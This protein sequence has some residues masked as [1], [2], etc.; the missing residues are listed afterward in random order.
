MICHWEGWGSPRQGFPGPPN[1]RHQTLLPVFLKNQKSCVSKV[2][3]NLQRWEELCFPCLRKGCVVGRCH[4]QVGTCFWNQWLWDVLHNETWMHFLLRDHHLF[5]QEA[6]L[7][8]PPSCIWLLESSEKLRCSRPLA[9][10]PWPWRPRCKLLKECCLR[11]WLGP[12]RAEALGTNCSAVLWSLFWIFGIQVIEVEE[13]V[14]KHPRLLA[15]GIWGSFSPEKC[16]ASP[17][18]RKKIF[19]HLLKI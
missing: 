8:F 1:I 13:G 14:K 19:N 16:G 18:V 15:S 10:F 2:Q 5:L 7:F 4:G 6:L 11:P 3:M 17:R 9:S 12:R